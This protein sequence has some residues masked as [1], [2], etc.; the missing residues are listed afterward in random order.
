M[1]NA[2]LLFKEIVDQ[3]KKNKGF[4]LERDAKRLPNESAQDYLK[5]IGK[6]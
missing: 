2:N 5:R 3:I 6:L 1:P 4:V